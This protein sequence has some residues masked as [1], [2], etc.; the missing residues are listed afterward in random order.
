MK[1]MHKRSTL[2]IAFCDTEIYVKEVLVMLLSKDGHQDW[3]VVNFY[4]IVVMRG[5]CL[6]VRKV[7]CAL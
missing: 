2:C 7:V 3:Y 1:W 4:K 6:A 5:A